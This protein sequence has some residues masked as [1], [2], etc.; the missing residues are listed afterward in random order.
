MILPKHEVWYDDYY[1]S[2]INVFTEWKNPWG[3]KFF[4]WLS[5][6]KE[7]WHVSWKKNEANYFDTALEEFYTRIAEKNPNAFDEI[8]NNKQIHAMM[9]SSDT[10]WAIQLELS[11]A[12][13]YL[14]EFEWDPEYNKYA[15]IIYKWVM[16]NSMYNELNDFAARK[17]NEY[18][19]DWYLPKKKDKFSAS[20]IRDNKELYMEFK[21]EFVDRHWDDLMVADVEWMQS[22]MFKFLVES[23]RSVSD[24]FFVEKEIDWEKKY[25]MKSALK[26]Q[27]Q[28]LIDFEKFMNEW[29]W[30]AAIAQWTQLTK[31]FSYDH[32]VSANTAAHIIN[33]IKDADNLSDEMKL[34]AM[35]EFAS[36]NLD[37]FAWNS[38]LYK[39]YPE[40]YE[41]VKKHYNELNYQVNQDLINAAND[42]A[43]SLS[44]DD[45]KGKWGKWSWLSLK[46][47]SLSEALRKNQQATW[48]K[49]RTEPYT[50][51]WMKAPI[52]DPTKVFVEDSKPL[53][54]N[55]TSK[56]Y[57]PK[58]NLGWTEKQQPT[59][60][61]VKVK[62]VKVK[63]KDIEVI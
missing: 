14:K 27:A 2:I 17:T 63:E 38:D 40:I 11:W 23:D 15:A 31:T 4:E 48:W 13:K 12:M 42:Y 46:T 50:M 58:T 57:T 35:T 22:A 36:N 45:S 56:W 49:R 29:N 6:F 44:S 60:K 5:N 43:L 25:Y 55:F 7:Y 10:A 39:D 3:S 33:R 30:E 20:E 53:K 1:N 32:I 51:T 61:P 62:K 8:L 18:K 59:A 41:E 19:A 54:V 24:K 26:S 21:K 28:Q 47:K 37:A 34:E 9:A 52:I 16:S